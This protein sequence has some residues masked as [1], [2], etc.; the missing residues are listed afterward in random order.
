[1]N[2][3]DITFHELS[4]KSVVKR[5]VPSDKEGFDVWQDACV[6]ISDQELNIL[7]NDG[8]YVTLNRKYIVRMDTQEVSDP[9]EKVLSRKDEIIGVVNTL[10]NMGF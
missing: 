10:S 4:G 1:M 7:I 9:T 5:N 3:Y 8:T 6:K 2:Y